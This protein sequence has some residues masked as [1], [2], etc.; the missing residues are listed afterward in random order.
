LKIAS[1]TP[2][3]I[4]R[5]LFVRLESDKGFAGVGE[6]GADGEGMFSLYPAA[7]D[8]SPYLQGEGLG[9]GWV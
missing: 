2:H 8:A 4:D 1:I 5:F 6:S 7:R 9:W 3:L